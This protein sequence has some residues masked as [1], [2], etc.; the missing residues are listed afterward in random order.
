MVLPLPSSPAPRRFALVATAIGVIVLAV[1]LAGLWWLGHRRVPESP[2]VRMAAAIGVALAPAAAGRDTLHDPVERALLDFYRQRGNRA[3]WSDDRRPHDAALAC[4]HVL[5][6]AA[7]EG[8]DPADYEGAALAH[9]CSRLRA[10]SQAAAPESLAALDLRLTRAFLRYARDACEGRVPD[11]ALDPDWVKDR[12]RPDLL[13]EL[14]RA[15]HAGRTGA[16][17]AELGPRD[18]ESL[19]LRA[20]LAQVLHVATLGGWPRLTAGPPLRLGDGSPDVAR[21]RRRLAYELPLDTTSLDAPFDAALLRAVSTFQGRHGIKPTGIVDP[22]T[23]AALN[24]P[25]AER[26]RTLA[27]NLERRRWLALPPPEPCII[28]NLPDY[29]LELRDSARTVLRMRVVIGERRNPTP[30]FS[31]AMSYLA[32]NPTW[33][34]PRRIVVEEIVPELHR[35]T[36]YLASH[37][38]RV[39]DPRHQPAL[40]VPHTAVDWRAAEQD[41]FRYI[42]VQDGGPENPLGRIKFMCPNE[43]DV[44]LHDTPLRSHF[45]Q[46]A[47]ARSHGCVRVER[48]HALAERLLAP[49]YAE[50]VADSV[51]SLEA[52]AVTRYVGLPHPVPVHLLYWTAWVDSAGALQYRDDIY[53]IDRRLD[54]A[55]RRGRP[56]EFVLNPPLE[57]GVL[58]RGAAAAG[59]AAPPVAG[60]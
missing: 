59:P 42:V 4:A 10:A 36:S 6:L 12:R 24:V 57:W 40:E 17:M 44:Y 11:A 8:L 56:D 15:L 25:A 32:F 3:A 21:L 46:V 39:F 9:D 23:R 33:R 26:A 22:P 2:A 29:S 41:S 50:A 49:R 1:L 18:P 34:L 7:R 48:P 45:A 38:M 28:V 14:A 47:R 51:D 5:A 43:Y 16:V 60:P 55:L 30:V 52:A 20:A 19:A 13:G 58:H 54:A 37:H 53:E 27:L 31:D 35:D